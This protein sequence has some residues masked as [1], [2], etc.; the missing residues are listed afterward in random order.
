MSS[1]SL[2]Y[3][4]EGV[5]GFGAAGRLGRVLG[6][7]L[8]SGSSGQALQAVPGPKLVQPPSKDEVGR[9]R[10]QTDPGKVDPDLRRPLSLSTPV[11][12]DE[13]NFTPPARTP[14]TL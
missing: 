8:T 13:K 14:D 10:A 3:L 4:L 9:A 7:A 12:P 2:D 5:P 6:Q 1:S 11:D